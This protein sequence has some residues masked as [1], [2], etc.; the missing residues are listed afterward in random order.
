MPPKKKKSRFRFLN[1]KVLLIVLGLLAVSAGCVVYGLWAST[2]DLKDVAKMP[3]RSA[4]YDMDGKLYSRLRG[5]NRVIVPLREVSRPFINALLAREDT[6]FRKHHGV[7]ALG[8]LR[9]IMRNITHLSA[10]EGAS[11][12]TQQLAR[13]SFPLG[14]HNLHRKV[15]EAFVATRIE[16]NFT[17]DQILESYVNRI[18]FGSGMWG[19]ET[20][21]QAYFGKPAAKLS[22][23]ESA[24][25]VGIIRSPNR[26][27]PFKNIKGATVQR[28]TVL[29][30][31]V[32]LKMISQ[33]QA[34]EAI[35]TKITVTRK[36]SPVAQ[37]NYAMDGLIRD[38]DVLLTDDQLQEGGLKIY[39]TIDPE[40]QTVS[41]R[42]LDLELTRIERRPGYAHPKK[43]D[44]PAQ[45]REDEA[46]TAYL[47]GALVLIDNR[48]GAIRALVG[49]RDYDESK[50]NRA[51]MAKRQI[52]STF[53]PFVY[54]AAF[55]R[56]HYPGSAVD[57][58][59]IRA[60]ELRDVPDWTPENS[61]GKYRGI[62][63]LEE[64][65]IQS[66]NTMT[67]R[68]GE[69]AGMKEV[70]RVAEAAGLSP[71]PPTPSSY[72]GAFEATLKELTVAYTTFPNAGVRK[73]SYLIERIDDSD[74][75]VLYRSAHLS[76][77]AL[78][79]GVSWMVS[80]TLEKVI[81]RGTAATA[82]SLGFTKPAAG[83]TGTTN[84][85]HDAWF[86]GYTKSLTCGVWV[87]LDQPAKIM[88]KG[89]GSALA[90]PIWVD[91]MKAASAVRYPAG[92]LQPPVPL[93]HVDLCSISDE[94]ATTGCSAARTAYDLD[95]PANRAPGKVC[96]VHRGR[97]LGDNSPSRDYPE[98]RRA[99][100][101]NKIFKSFRKFFTR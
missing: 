77:A 8:I 92:P 6:R 16:Q 89:Y 78:D 46:P 101:A 42:S 68:V 39:T 98:E 73:Q 12:I 49:G 63:N 9:A 82:K 33:A 19:V 74:G 18:Y 97:A 35:R 81:T 69:R 66:R 57:D 29:G 22:L 32:Q 91:V 23:S 38:L 27:S 83:K 58:S 62:Q 72:L 47:Q 100:P 2:F 71:V 52:G 37:E 17:K 61:D 3:E 15:L 25:L 59:A 14:G 87:G 94:I 60:G 55:K 70:V 51:L 50:F 45:S 79:P 13:N 28:D 85:Y 11:T 40:L 1:W 48:S 30:R 96:D 7:D 65:L 84:D 26:F 54:A 20:A 76:A 64:G 4:V 41:L 88:A 53:K 75:R 93:E 95:V 24:M 36:R 56:G 5:E 34:D 86:V 21:S 90:L 31:M 80:S 10:K 43:A 67:V 99:T 44:F